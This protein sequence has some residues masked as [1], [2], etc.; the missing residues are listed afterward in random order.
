LGLL[1]ARVTL[2]AETRHGLEHGDRRGDRILRLLELIGQAISFGLAGED[3]H[4]R[5]GIDEHQ[6]S[7]LSSS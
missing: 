6:S 5:R 2:A 4:D 3:G 7:P 1:D